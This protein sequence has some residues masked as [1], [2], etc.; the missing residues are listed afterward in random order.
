MAD[1]L[2][3]YEG[4]TEGPWKCPGMIDDD[5]VF[6]PKDGKWVCQLWSKQ[7]ENF[8]SDE[9]TAANAELIA[10]AP[11]ILSQLNEAVE[12]LT[13]LSETFEF[14]SDIKKGATLINSCFKHSAIKFLSSI[15]GK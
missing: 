6:T 3:K 11:L 14:P 4:H 13:R 7:E 9:E 2:D 1:I 8:R 5:I 10:D 12:L 15:G